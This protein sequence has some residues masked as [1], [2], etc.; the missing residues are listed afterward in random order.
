M[1]REIFVEIIKVPWYE[2]VVVI[3]GYLILCINL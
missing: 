3:I 1:L 2:A